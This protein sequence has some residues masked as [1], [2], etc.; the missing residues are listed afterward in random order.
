MC[1][2][3]LDG[4]HVK[5]SLPPKSGSLYY[6]YKGDFSIVLMA[7][8]G[9][10]LKFLFVDVGTNGR[11]SD[12]GVWAKCKLKSALEKN[13]I[14]IP[15]ANF[16]SGT[17]T[18]VPYV[19]VADEAFPLS[20]N[21]MKPFPG[22]G[23]NV[24][25]RIFNYR[26]SRARRV[27]ENAFGILAARFQIFKRRILTNPANATK[28]VIA[29]CA[30]HNFLIANNS[31]I[32]TPPSSIDVEDINSRQIRTGDWRN[33]SSKA[34]VPLIKQCNKKPAELAKDVRHTFRTYFNGIG[35]V[36]WQEDMCMYQ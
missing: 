20:F 17:L 32:Y 11:I 31:A 4:K 25:E 16:L 18:K 8:V 30:L 12:G 21:L 19:I 7:L 27:S 22:R 34:L 1:I 9:A 33:Y 26:L 6:N 28:M 2:G 35:A 5:I 13:K 15:K 29:C 10:D 23:V 14:K 36:P 3:A 24:E